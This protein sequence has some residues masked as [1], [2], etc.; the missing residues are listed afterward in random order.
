MDHPTPPRYAPA[1][2]FPPYAFL[3]GRDPHPTG[4]P[5]GHS[6]SAERAAP[7][8]Y[9][10]AERW[11]ENE[12]YLF[13]CDLYNHG[14]LWEA[15]EAWEGLWHRARQDTDQAELLQGLI[16]CAAACLKIPMQQPGGRARLAE[17]GTARLERVARAR[18]G[19]HMGL[20]LF[21]LVRDFR[22]F[23]ALEAPELEARPRLELELEA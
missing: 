20:E 19:H 16:Q 5:R 12:D 3:P 11:R 21:G 10:P 15:H 1:R 23:A 6:Y 17:A 14:Y 13:G 18:G 4:D 9:L 7:A 8:A 2:T 22:A